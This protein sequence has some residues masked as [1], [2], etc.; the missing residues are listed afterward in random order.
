M[1]EL[2]DAE[3]EQEISEFTI[4]DIDLFEEIVLCEIPTGSSVSH[5]FLERL[6]NKRKVLTN[7]FQTFEILVP[8]LIQEQ[9][10]SGDIGAQEPVSSDFPNR[11]KFLVAHAKW[12]LA[13]SDLNKYRKAAENKQGS[14]TVEASFRPDIS[15]FLKTSTAIL[16]PEEDLGPLFDSSLQSRETPKLFDGYEDGDDAS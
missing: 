16:E 11:A 5:A 12:K 1:W 15:Q 13:H 9:K 8:K 14:V 7:R 6:Q 2:F 3:T 10:A 4:A